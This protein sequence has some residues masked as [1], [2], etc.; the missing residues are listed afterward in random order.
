MMKTVD[1]WQSLLIGFLL[2]VVA[3]MAYCRSD[4]GR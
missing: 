4:R 1:F 2:G 3:I